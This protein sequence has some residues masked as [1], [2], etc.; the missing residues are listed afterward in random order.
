MLQFISWYLVIVF[1]GMIFFPIIYKLMPFLTDH[2][3]CFSRIAGLLVWGY[4]FWILNIFGIIHNNLNGIL[5]CFLLILIIAC[6]FIHGHD[7]NAMIYWIKD[8]KKIVLVSEILF[9]LSFLIWTIV[10]AANPDISGTEKP[11]ELAFINS[12][13]RSPSFPPADPWLSGYSISYYYFGYVMVAMLAK[14]ANTPSSIA[15]NLA[16]SAWFALTAIGCYGVVFNLLSIWQTHHKVDRKN[17]RHSKPNILLASL[18]GPFF[19]L[20]ISNAEGFLEMLHSKGLFWKLDL[21]GMFTS[22]FWAWLNMQE[23]NQPP[24]AP[25]SWIPERL[26]GIWWW[27]ASRVL[28]DFDIVGNAKEIIDEFPFF[29]YLLGDLH[30]HLLAMPF[31]LLTL[32]I[33]LN[34]HIGGNT[35]I[36]LKTSIR[37]WLRKP[38]FWFVVLVCGG[39][40]FLNTW[41]LPAFF[42]FILIIFIINRIT[43]CGW[44]KQRIYEFALA[45]LLLGISSLIAYLPFF[46]GF[47]SQA[48]GILPSIN[49][50][51]RG[52][53]FWIMFLPFIVINLLF[54]IWLMNKDQEKIAIISGMKFSFLLILLLGIGS[55]T[56]G[57]IIGNASN[58]LLWFEGI[59]NVQNFTGKAS[60][61]TLMSMFQALHGSTDLNNTIILSLK[62]RFNS[63]FTLITL[64]LMVALT[65][66]CVVPVLTKKPKNRSKNKSA[67]I[68]NHVYL[69]ILLLIFLGAI[70]CII[71]EFF[72]LKDVFGTRMNTIFKF[73]FQTWIIWGL[74]ASAGIII[75][76]V[77]INKGWGYLLKISFI[78]LLIISLAYPFWSLL[79]KTNGFKPIEW[80][81]DGN[82]Y[83]RRYNENEYNAIEWFNTA[84]YGILAE[85]VGGSYSNSAR[86]SSLTGLP[87]VLGWPGH[88]LQWRGGVREMGSREG[89]IQLLYS[90]PDWLTA[91]EVIEKYSI[92]YIYIGDLERS[93][94]TIIED[95]FQEFLILVFE[96]STVRIYE[97]LVNN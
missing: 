33:G 32:G 54:L 51:T 88:E 12:I 56:I 52:I 87:T 2:G 62:N 76:W 38:F 4:L 49:F 6:L 14:L 60:I 75:L 90:T 65:V 85:A 83:M 19:V 42:G 61:S 23:L 58:L 21:N 29:T 91:K 39:I 44:G 78:I 55:Y 20:I 37:V 97:Y 28:Q 5:F 86:I 34:L 22:K 94:Y 26:G 31:V 30:P 71:P 9:L 73:Y 41:D 10:R 92:R 11:M 89:D 36:Y 15:F 93:K 64:F 57:I 1:I 7:W 69:P 84:D 59:F 25:F 80:T 79:S 13:L 53:H 63:P 8:N 67:R 35:E 17:T 3:Y 40:A 66:A 74:A 70:L 27:R 18:F 47:S 16:I 95:K 81:L 43:K 46:L 72:Y 50:F 96:N 68:L 82:A 24:T 48:G 45:G 77:E